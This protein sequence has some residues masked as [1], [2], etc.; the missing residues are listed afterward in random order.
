MT[1]SGVWY[2]LVGDREGCVT[3]YIPAV[4]RERGRLSLL[5]HWSVHQQ[6]LFV[7]WRVYFLYGYLGTSNCFCGIYRKLTTDSFS[8]VYA[9]KLTNI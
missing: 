5:P 4:V 3:C 6:Q 7:D 2:D 8:D 1:E 9:C